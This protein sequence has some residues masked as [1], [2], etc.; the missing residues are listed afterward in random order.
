MKIAID[1]H[2]C[3]FELS[4]KA[5]MRYTELCGVKLYCY[6]A[7]YDKDDTDN[8]FIEYVERD[9]DQCSIYYFTEPLKDNK[10]DGRDYDKVFHCVN[11][12]RNDKNLIQVIEEMGR[13]ASDE[14]SYIKIVEIPD[15]VQWQ[16]DCM[17][18]WDREKVVEKHREWK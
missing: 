15:D 12:P 8:C 17:G 11:I 5:V 14:N 6:V 3:Y 4:H 13:K 10:W 1:T 9:N 7:D 16:I 18:D 2:S